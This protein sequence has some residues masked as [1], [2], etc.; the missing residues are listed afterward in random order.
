LHN[1]SEMV[2]AAISQGADKYARLMQLLRLVTPEK[3]TGTKYRNPQV[4]AAV[5]AHKA[6][7]DELADI[8]RR[9]P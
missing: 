3:G 6:M 1:V 5:A 9:E 7:D 4:E 8:L 2:G